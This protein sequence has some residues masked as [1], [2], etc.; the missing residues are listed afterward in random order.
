MSVRM[1]LRLLDA[2]TYEMVLELGT[3]G[4]DLKPCQIMKLHR[5]N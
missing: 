4:E 2:E 3:R 5:V 1:I